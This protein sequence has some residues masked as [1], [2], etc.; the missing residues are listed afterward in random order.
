[1]HTHPVF[2]FRL[3]CVLLCTL[4]V[5]ASYNLAGQ[6]L[7]W[8]VQHVSIEDGL[9]NRFVNSI[10]QDDRG[11]MW[12]GTNFGLN[13]YIGHRMDVLTQQNSELSGNTIFDLQLDFKHNIWI[14]HRTQSNFPISDID[15]ID[16]LTFRIITLEEYIGKPLPF[17]TGEIIKVSAGEDRAIYLIHNNNSIFKFDSTGLRQVRPGI[18]E[19]NTIYSGLSKVGL[20]FN[21]IR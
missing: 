14:V 18:A 17:S 20:V 8:K 1:M 15:I 9:S 13:R 10:I 21:S 2:Q 16:P 12:I 5:M 11:F 6:Q 3:A 4:V 7:N 19:M